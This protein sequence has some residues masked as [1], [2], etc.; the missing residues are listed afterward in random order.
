VDESS[1]T[2]LGAPHKDYLN[3]CN[4]MLYLYFVDHA[5]ELRWPYG[6][7]VTA[8]I[9]LLQVLLLMKGLGLLRA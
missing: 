9:K 4:K 8:D 7:S 5:S 2:A 3:T 1:A 6:Q